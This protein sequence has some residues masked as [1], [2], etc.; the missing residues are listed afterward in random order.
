MAHHSFCRQ[1]GPARFAWL[2]GADMRK[3]L[4]AL[5]LV[6]GLAPQARS[7]DST[8]AA[9]S[10]ASALDGTE[11]FYCVQGGADRKCTPAQINTYVLSLMGTGIATFLATPSSANLAA[12]VT[13]ETGSGALVFA[14][15]PTLVT[16][17][18][19]TPSAAV[20][21]N[22][23]GLPLST[24]V[25]GN[26]PV[27]NLNSGTSASATTFWRGD[28]TW[29][30]AVTQIDTACGVSG[31]PITTTGTVQGAAV[32][33]AHTGTTDTIL[34]ADCGKVVTA[35]N[36]SAVA[37]TL[38]QA[39][40]SFTAPFFFTQVNLGA[41]TVTITPT[42]S[43]INGAATLVLTTGQSADIVS[44]GTNY[45]A[46]LGRGGAPTTNA[47]DLTSGT[48]AAARLPAFTGDC[49][50]SAGTAATVCTDP[51]PGYV[52]SNWYLGQGPNLYG[53]S[54]AAT[55]NRISCYYG[56][57]PRVITIRNVGFGIVTAGTS[58]TQVALYRNSGGN[59]GALIDS[60]P[61]VVNT[62]GTSVATGALGADQQIGPG[63]ANGRDIWHCANQ[64]DSTITYR[65]VTGA[66]TI[67]GSQFVGSATVTNILGSGP[68][69][70]IGKLCSGANCNGGSSTFGT[71][72]ATLAG[73]TWTDQTGTASMPIIAVQVVSSP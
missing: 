31:G 50:T 47:A 49:T 18:L 7:A 20:L 43:T 61:S 36:G 23:T 72:P 39:T 62:G 54:G 22:A 48:L 5:A 70:I 15:S 16:P 4:L 21:T 14:T 60:T 40:G 63:T 45:I 1:M 71:W 32:V 33:R 44:D 69:A 38:P 55:A 52:V 41:G 66:N 68:T 27:T 17:A 2:E 9:M 37:V 11:L 28:G 29:G 65:S 67:S 13:N 8:V 51:H 6:L 57:Y 46:I 24:G 30:A 58:N 10:A 73:T 64:N 26:L 59:P 12:A 35:S 3:I 53:T 34:A 42:T 25:T 56:Y 19:G